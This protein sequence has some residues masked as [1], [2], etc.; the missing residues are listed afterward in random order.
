MP[1]H[2]RPLQIAYLGSPQFSADLLEALIAQSLQLGILISVVFTQPDKPAGRGL[3]LRK[4]PVKQ[5]AER[6]G[7]P[8]YCDGIKANGAASFRI[9]H[10]HAIDLCILFA[11]HE[12]IPAD[13]LSAP[14]YGFWN[15][16]PSLLPHYRG[17]SPLAYALLMGETNSGVS[18]MHMNQKMDEGDIIDQVVFPLAHTDTQETLQKKLLMLNLHLL[19]KHLSHAHAVNRTPQDHTRATYTRKLTRADGY[20]GYTTLHNL[21][22]GSTEPIEGIKLM[23]DF[24]L[25]NPNS[26]PPQYLRAHH[27]YN[28]WRALHPWPGVWTEVV[29]KNVKKRLK[30]IAMQQENSER[31][32][33]TQG[34]IEGDS[35]KP[36]SHIISAISS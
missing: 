1:T 15:I 9:L 32:L 4:T 34:Q 31:T 22:D 23:Q 5:V 3:T 8:C 21:I 16:H 20:I 35:V 14:P 30:I 17:A 13:V 36:W 24:Y 19:S 11:Y 6:N 2:S 10:E 25:R 7:I 33:I 12:M 28:M 18:L 27:L 29:I 26:T